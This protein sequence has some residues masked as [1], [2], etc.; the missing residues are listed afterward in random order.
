MTI[1]K[2]ECAWKTVR[3][4][5]PHNV[6][7]WH[8]VSA[9]PVFHKKKTTPYLI[10]HNFGKCWPIFK[11][12]F[13]FG[14]SRDR[15]LNWSLKVHHASDSIILF[16]IVRVI[17]HLYVCMYHTLKVSIPYL[18]K[19][20]CQETTDNLKQM[21]RLIINFNLIYSVNN[22]FANLCHGEY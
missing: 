4:H 18:V 2:S 10:A 14:L 15:V 16:D 6:T 5:L 12:V 22:V 7:I 8:R 13:T 9:T 3:A 20:K 21:S 19:C 11:F 1:S 17:N